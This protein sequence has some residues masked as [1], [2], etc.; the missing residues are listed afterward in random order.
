MKKNSQLQHPTWPAQGADFWAPPP[1]PSM[2]GHMGNSALNNGYHTPPIL[3]HQ[4][5]HLSLDHHRRSIQSRPV[6]QHYTFI[7]PIDSIDTNSPPHPPIYYSPHS[8]A[9]PQRQ[10]HQHSVSRKSHS[11][12]S[13][14]HIPGSNLPVDPSHKIKLERKKVAD[15]TKKIVIAGEYRLRNGNVVNIKAQME[16]AL[17]HVR[18]YTPE[19]YL[20][21]VVDPRFTE[22]IVEVKLIPSASE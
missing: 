6:L 21:E 4:N 7:P 1:P 14:R 22:M 11:Q 13:P 5:H 19:D 20:V 16:Y 18:C 15:E 17:T 9:Q 10:Q 8:I 3:H 2:M 12:S